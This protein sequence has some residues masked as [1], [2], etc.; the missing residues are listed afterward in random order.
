M[1]CWCL[2]K[3][4]TFAI[5]TYEKESIC[6]PMDAMVVRETREEEQHLLP[7]LRIYFH[8]E[9]SHSGHVSLQPH[10]SYGFHDNLPLMQWAANNRTLQ[11]KRVPS[12]QRLKGQAALSPSG[13]LAPNV[14]NCNAKHF[15][16]TFLP[17][18]IPESTKDGQ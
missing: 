13:F 17:P 18:Y 9:R 15:E 4:P 16:T 10:Q 7:H 2:T 6:F 14:R 11:E 3:K 5:K 1:L 12:L 8:T